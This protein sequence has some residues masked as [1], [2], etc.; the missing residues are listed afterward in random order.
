[1]RKVTFGCIHDKISLKKYQILYLLSDFI[2]FEMTENFLYPNFILYF[3]QKKNQFDD[4][5][6]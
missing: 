6:F 2:L 4:S 1:M 5:D 3:I